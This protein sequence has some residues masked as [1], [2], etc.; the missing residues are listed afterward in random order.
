ML[1]DRTEG[2]MHEV[3]EAMISTREGLSAPRGR[4]RVASP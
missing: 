2:P 3:T 4:L 1:M